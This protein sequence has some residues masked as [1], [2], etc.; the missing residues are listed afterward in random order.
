VKPER[1]LARSVA[2][3][4]GALLFGRMLALLAGIATVTITSRYLGARDFG[5]LTA[6]MAYA[7]LFALLTDLGMSTVATREIARAPEREREIV[8]NVISVGLLVAIAAAAVGLTLMLL[9]YSG[10]IH[11]ATREAIVIL[12]VQV[13][14]A[15]ITGATRARFTARQR[16]YL[17]ALGDVALAIGM[18]GLTAIAAGAHLGFRLVVVAVTG[19]YVLQAIVM[20]AIALREGGLSVAFDRV[21]ASR[22][23]RSALPLGGIL[24][25]NYLYFRL[26]VLLLSW[27]KTDVDVAHYGLAYRVLE[28][29]MVLPGY[30]MLALFPEIARSEND[31]ARLRATVGAALG[32]LEAVSLPAVALLATFS[33]EIV[34]L[35]GTHSY[36]ASGPVLAILALALG[37]S[38]L[39]GV[40]GNALVALGRQRMLFWVSVPTLLVNLV[41]N[42]L[43]IPP[44][45]VDGAAW[46]VVI[47]EVVALAT[48]RWAYVRVAGAPPAPPH[49][50]ILAAGSALGALAAIKFALSPALG[51][52]ALVLGGGAVGL[53]VY[54]ALILLLGALPESILV[55]LPV[56]RHAR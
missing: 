15:P 14:V 30:L 1:S 12:L 39:N 24:L 2:L 33:S 13:L 49:L 22:L 19:G 48:V 3:T 37:I 28:G 31:P 8:G 17:V 45:G 41:A 34:V 53:V 36:D 55:R 51:D 29:L 10:R 20:A 50:R 9:V 56:L 23:V 27:I 44:Y 21:I 6:A 7:S 40:Y 25:I 5:A 11:T 42:L 16:G 26:D 32:V 18:A 38:Y 46:A 54:A 47:S 4:T 35:L 43:L 52:L